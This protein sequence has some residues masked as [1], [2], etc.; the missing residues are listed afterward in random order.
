MTTRN[1]LIAIAAAMGLSVTGALAQH[2]EHYQDQATPTAAHSETGQAGTM[3]S[4]G[5]MMGQ[6]ETGKMVEQLIRNLAAIEEEKDLTV[7]KAKLA[8]Q[9]ALL[10]ELRAKV[11]AQSQMMD[12]MQHMMVGSMMDGMM[13]D[14]KLMDG[15]LTD[16]KLI[17]VKMTY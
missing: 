11:Q 3:M 5:I 4:G 7:V 2:E 14:G 17:D 6:N 1:K 12:V 15:K 8:R 16:G 10:K 9:G 13:M